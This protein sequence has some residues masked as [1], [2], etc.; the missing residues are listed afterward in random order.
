MDGAAGPW[1]AAGIRLDADEEAD[2]D[3]GADATGLLCAEPPTLAV[4][5]AAGEAAMDG[6]GF[7]LA[8]EGA[9]AEG[10]LDDG[11]AVDPPH[12]ANTAALP[13]ARDI[14][15]NCRLFIGDSDGF[16]RHLL[17]LLEW[18]LVI[19]LLDGYRGR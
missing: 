1:F 11:A 9:P 18:W 8:T 13:A 14:R 10:A 3:G 6:D 4:P 12:A 5:D 19:P 2:A 17:L 7:A 15:R 16:L